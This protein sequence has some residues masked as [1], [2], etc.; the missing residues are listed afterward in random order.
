MAKLYISQ[1]QLAKAPKSDP[2]AEK[3]YSMKPVVRVTTRYRGDVDQESK[4]VFPDAYVHTHKYVNAE[5]KT[6]K[7]H[8]QE[9]A[10]DTF[11]K[12]MVSAGVIKDESEGVDPN[13]FD[14]NPKVVN[15]ETGEIKQTQ[16]KPL[17]EFN[18][19]AFDA[20][21]IMFEGNQPAFNTAKKQEPSGAE[22][23]EASKDDNINYRFVANS[24]KPTE[25]PFTKETYDLAKAAIADAAKTSISNSMNALGQSEVAKQEQAPATQTQTPQNNIR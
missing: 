10:V 20:N 24:V 17:P 13:W 25:V 16:F 5:N 21:V 6:V 19:K 4:N 11:N 12:M 23:V 15:K 22:L 7:V 2:E 14:K 1:T 8:Y 3:G 9:F 18:G